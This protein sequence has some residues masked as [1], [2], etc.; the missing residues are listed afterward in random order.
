MVRSSRASAALTICA[1]AAGAGCGGSKSG[2]MDLNEALN[3]INAASCKYQVACGGLP[4]MATC[5]AIIQAPGYQATV[6][7][8]IASG[9]VKYDATKA[10]ACVDLLERVYGAG[11]TR[12]G[13]VSA[14]GHSAGTVACDGVFA[15]TVTLGGSCF[16]SE[17]CM[18]GAYCQPIDSNCFNFLQ[19]CAGN[20]VAEPPQVSAGGDCSEGQRCP[21]GYYCDPALSGGPRTCLATLAE[22]AACA[23]EADCAEPLFCDLDPATQTGTC[24]RPAASGG[25]CNAAISV[26]SCDDVRD[27]CDATTATCTPRGAPGASCADQD[28]CVSYASCD[29]TTC[30]AAAGLGETCGG[31]NGIGCLAGL[32]CPSP[33]YTCMP[34]PAVDGACM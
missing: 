33:G 24:R 26:P 5:V 31:A 16:F 13:Q 27:H 22:G 19:C 2:P 4:D 14:G 34:P 32:Q 15:G 9:T 8:D 11:C 18:D 23:P 30:V 7:Q 10:A 28:S 20:C 29:G 1:L 17:E 6:E 3:R 25:S 21:R 12:S